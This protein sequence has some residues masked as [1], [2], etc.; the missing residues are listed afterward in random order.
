MQRK[1]DMLE[2]HLKALQASRVWLS[3]SLS[4]TANQLQN[5]AFV[6]VLLDADHIKVSQASSTR[7]Q[8]C[9]H[10]IVP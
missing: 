7:F 6:L 8:R 3:L 10:L 2:G 1:I 4:L 9:P 5:D